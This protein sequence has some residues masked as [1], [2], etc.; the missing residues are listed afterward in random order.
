[1]F[2]YIDKI[3]KRKVKYS[4]IVAIILF[5]V[6][7]IIYL[8]TYQVDNQVDYK[9]AVLVISGDTLKSTDTLYYDKYTDEEIKNMQIIIKE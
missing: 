8:F 9:N 5:Y 7:G 6:I 3:K 2:Y 4:V 1:M